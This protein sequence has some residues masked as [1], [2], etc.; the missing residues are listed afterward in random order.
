MTLK[1]HMHATAEEALPSGAF[2]PILA[3]AWSTLEIYRNGD[4]SVL[5][6]ARL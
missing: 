3:G 1:P 4:D 6:K 5:G 2:P